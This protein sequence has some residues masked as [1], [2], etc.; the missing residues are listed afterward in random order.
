MCSGIGGIRH[1]R[2]GVDLCGASV[3]VENGNGERTAATDCATGAS[4]ANIIGACRKKAKPVA[5]CAA[6]WER[7]RKGNP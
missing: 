3:F 7:G 1:Q 5:E 4:C 6:V 2:L